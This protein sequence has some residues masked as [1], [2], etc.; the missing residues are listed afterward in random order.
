M[1]TNNS[2]VILV[3]GGAGYIGS[4]MVWKLKQAGFL[5]IVLD[6]LSKGHAHAA[7][8]AKLIIGDMQDKLLLEN[9]FAQYP[10]EAVMHFA[11]FIEV[12]ESVRFPL[13]YYQNNVC[14]TLNLLEVMRKNK[15]KHFIFSSTAAVYGQP[16]YAPIDEAHPLMPINPYGHSKKMVEQIIQDLANSEDLHFALL[17]YFNAAGA[18]Q[19]GLLG[20][21]HEPESHLIPL[22][23]Q[24]AL[25]KRK[26][27]TIYGNDYDTPDGT[28][29][30]DYIHVLDLCEAHLLALYQLLA[31]KKSII[32]NLGTGQGYSVLEVINTAK[33]VTKINIP[34]MMGERRLGDPA[35]LVADAKCA[36]K[37]LAWEPIYSNLSTIIHDAWKYAIINK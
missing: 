10:I 37:L 32:C 29:I 16:Q 12:G 20:E 17:R 15:I 25:G 28:C 5:P 34:V 36:N 3:V 8:D 35:V 2:P 26:F 6:N 13:K 30:R 19:A 22:I 14:A 27:I 18:H 24:T 31:G 33:E 7:L 4:H 9:I 23:L 11:S 1:P 21:A